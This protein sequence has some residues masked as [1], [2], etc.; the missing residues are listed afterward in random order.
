MK[1]VT[2]I[3]RGLMLYLLPFF[4]Y[5]EMMKCILKNNLK[6][7]LGSIKIEDENFDLGYQFYGLD[8]E[9]ENFNKH[10]RQRKSQ[11]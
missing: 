9:T 8:K 4:E 7:V 5:G 1:K 10:V 6:G 2:I 11:F 3:D